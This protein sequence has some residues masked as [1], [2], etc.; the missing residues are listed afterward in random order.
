MTDFDGYFSPAIRR[1]LHERD[2]CFRCHK[3]A[4][5]G[6]AIREQQASRLQSASQFAE[7]MALMR[8]QYTDTQKVKTP[9]YAPASPAAAG[10]SDVYTAGLE[11]RRRMQKRFGSA[12]T[13]LVP[14]PSLGGAVPMAA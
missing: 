14:F 2:A 1:P 12:A 4:D 11:T 10:N 5:S 7:Q 8:Q 6:A 3:G 13:N 9:K